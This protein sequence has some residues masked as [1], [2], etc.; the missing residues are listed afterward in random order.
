MIAGYKLTHRGSGIPPEE[1][2]LFTGKDAIDREE[3][4]FLAREAAKGEKKANWFY[5]T[6]LA[7]LF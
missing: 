4:A 1:A 7:W 2:D 3:Q 6:F 5:R